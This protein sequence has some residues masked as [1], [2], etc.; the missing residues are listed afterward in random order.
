[1]REITPALTP[2]L[3]Y[4]VDTAGVAKTDAYPIANYRELVEHIARL[5]YLNKDHLLFYRGQPID[6]QNRAGTSSFYPSIYRGEQLRRDEVE[7]RF[8]TLE[9][10]ATRLREL[11]RIGRIEGHSDVARKKLV[12]WSLLQHYEVAATPLLDFTH[13]PRVACSFAMEPRAGDSVFVYVFGLPYLTNRISMNSEQDTVIVRLLSICPPSALR[14]YFQEGYLAGTP[15]VTN[16]YESKN[17]LDFSHRLIAKFKIPNSRAFWGEGLRGLSQEELYPANDEMKDLCDQIRLHEL[18]ST[19]AAGGTLGALGAFI[20]EWAGLERVM[21]RSAQRG[22]AKVP[23]VPQAIQQLKRKERVPSDLALEL[24]RLRRFR[25]E[26]VHG[27]RRSGEN[28]LRDAT[29]SAADV[30]RRLEDEERAWR[31]T[32]HQKPRLDEHEF[33][34]S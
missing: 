13:S 17:E 33:P 14:P 28:E 15:D 6:F 20:A 8:A 22:D 31:Q 2:E 5:A 7:F 3:E 1:M 10:A 4:H 29:Q 16:E 30:R 19:P 12:Q 26:V 21:M 32:F 25:N 24:E 34:M 9:R 23:S 11:F 18:D 27:Q